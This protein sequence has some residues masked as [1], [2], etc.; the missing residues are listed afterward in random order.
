MDLQHATLLTCRQL[1]EQVSNGYLRA[2][3][4]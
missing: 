4:K 1:L 2:L 3:H